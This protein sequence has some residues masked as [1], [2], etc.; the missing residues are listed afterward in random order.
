M[1]DIINYFKEKVKSNKTDETKETKKDLP[2]LKSFSNSKSAN[3][4]LTKKITIPTPFNLSLN[5]PKI[6]KEPIQISNEIKGLPIPKNLK[7]NSLK[8]IEDER[9]KRINS[10][11]K[12]IIERT[13]K[14]R[15]ALTLETEHRPNNIDKVRK[16]LENNIKKNL[17]FNQKFAK[18][19]K[20]FNKYKAD[21]K[22]NEAAILKE[23]Y[24]ID[25]RN[26][27]EEKE[28]NKI[29]IEKKDSKEFDRWVTEMNIKD[30]IERLEKIDKRKMELM[31][32]R[33]ISS[34]YYNLRKNRNMEKYSEQKMIGKMNMKKINE[35]KKEDI[36]D[37]KNIVEKIKKEEEN[38]ILKKLKMIQDNK[39][40]YQKRKK[41]F[42]ELN[43]LNSEEM[44]IQKEKRDNIVNQIRTLEKIP[45]KREIGFDPTE[46]P[47][48][49]LLGEMSLVELRER[50]SL[51]KRMTEDEL[52]CKKEENKLRIM[53]RADEIYNKALIIQENRNKLRERKEKERKYKKEQ[54]EIINEKYKIERENNIIKCKK[55]IEEKKRKM[56]KEDQDFLK[57]I[58]EI[59][60]GLQFGN[61]GKD[62]V[63]YK[64][65]ENNEIGLERKYNNIQ[66]KILEDKLIEEKINWERIKQRFKNAKDTNNYYKNIIK[67]YNNNLINATIIKRMMYDEDKQ[68]TKTV[69]DKE[70]AFKK[71]Q[72][73]D[74]K[75]RNKLSELLYLNILKNRKA[76]KS[77]VVKNRY[78]NNTLGNERSLK[79]DE[80]NEQEE[81]NYIRN[82]LETENNMNIK[83]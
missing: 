3:K 61:V 73:D 22:Y 24:L 75:S 77:V 44:K 21:V 30:D 51:Q 63:E 55:E 45:K 76:N 74:F 14:D 15:R 20:D 25:K 8:S 4:I 66:N 17:K 27:E 10:L 80:D 79:I 69:H 56:K 46:T 82:K 12:N 26:K 49:G 1:K 64:H 50:L 42:D 33:E 57:K 31:L 78:L 18:P 81:N 40:L 83:I 19:M 11:K 48:Y 36:K 5:K 37:K 70:R 68:Y 6:I 32:N 41:E 72:K 9:I 47:G 16:L 52:N 2:L 35:E 71:Y 7:S 28:L 58:R 67:N 39:S 34:N 62:Q 59:K 43:I 60:L 53:Q 65:N 29:L 13:E 54:N 38:A 23:E